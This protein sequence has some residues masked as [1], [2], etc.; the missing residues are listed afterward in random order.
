MILVNIF[1]NF[2]EICWIPILSAS[3]KH[4]LCKQ[5]KLTGKNG[6]SASI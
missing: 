1:A 2:Q 3:R 4:S 6:G 5:G